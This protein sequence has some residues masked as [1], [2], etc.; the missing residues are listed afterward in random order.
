MSNQTILIISPESWGKSK[1]SKHHYALA[2]ANRGMKVYFLNLN[3]GN[4]VKVDE[5]CVDH[6]NIVLTK[7][8]TPT[9]INKLRFHFRFLY[10]IILAIFI[11]A[12]TTKH[13]KLG[14]LISF[15]CNGVFTN[16]SLFNAKKTIFFPVDQVNE[17]YRK[18][19]KGFNQLLSISPVILRVC[20]IHNRFCTHL[21][22]YI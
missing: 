1:I 13:P 9:Y 21:V 16:L 18:S 7:I 20:G 3:V 11:K 8:N 2:L 22:G 6:D 10:D 14:L 17:K 15:D 19:Y 5:S 12:W 4:K